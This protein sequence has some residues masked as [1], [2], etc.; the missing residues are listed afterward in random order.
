[1]YPCNVPPTALSAHSPLGL[2]V[3][4]RLQ[5]VDDPEMGDESKTALRSIAEVGKYFR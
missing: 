5:T 2:R 3:R 4:L 1:M